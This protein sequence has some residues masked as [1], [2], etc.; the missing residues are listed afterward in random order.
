MRAFLAGQRAVR[1]LI[2]IL[3]LGLWGFSSI[4]NALNYT[5]VLARV[6]RV[7]EMCRPAGV[8]IQ[9]STNCVT[10][11]A[12]SNGKRLLRH[13]A[14]HVRYKS[15]ADGQEH[16]GVVIPIGSKMAL[17][18]AKLRPGDRWKILAHDDKPGDVH[19]E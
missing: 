4:K 12:N 18:A 13:T 6:E 17:Q 9:E 3:G 2:V 5:A 1:L 19:A 11:L 15:P 10:A 7:E 8:P 16:S 14:V